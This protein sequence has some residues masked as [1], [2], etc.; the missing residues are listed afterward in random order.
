MKYVS[1]KFLSA[2]CK[3]TS[4]PNPY[5]PPITL[6][7]SVVMPFSFPAAGYLFFVC[8]FTFPF[9]ILTFFHVCVHLQTIEK[10]TD[11]FSHLFAFLCIYKL[12]KRHL[13]WI[14]SDEN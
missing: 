7:T 9:V 1:I 10:P 11:I 5:K 14:M 13:K 2:F 3:K 8:F 4:E 12:N 6:T